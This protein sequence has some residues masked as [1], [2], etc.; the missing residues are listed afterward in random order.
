M[1]MTG[2]QK[3]A[4]KK[5]RQ[6]EKGRAKSREYD[7]NRAEQKK[8]YKQT[9]KY[10]ES[11]RRYRATD[12]Y[13]EAA[14]RYRK[15]PKGRRT[16]SEYQKNHLPT[17]LS[18]YLRRRL[19]MAMELGSKAG[20]AVRDLGCSINEFKLYIENQFQPGM[21]WDNY[22][23]WHLDHV[24]PLAYYDLSSRQ[25]FLEAC[26]YLNIQPLWA[27]DNLEKRRKI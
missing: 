27:K 3:I 18:R 20:S 25:E 1:P 17:K 11:Q 12:A 6:S 21:S 14:E 2:A 5:Y 4:Q 19:T 7:R 22:G 24:I 16:R 8:L 15:S 13:K 26:N 10:K 9:E 23:K